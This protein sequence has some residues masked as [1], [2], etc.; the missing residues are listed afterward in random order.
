[1]LDFGFVDDIK[2]I[3]ETIREHAKSRTAHE[4]EV[5]GRL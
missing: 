1:M 3:K 4:N 2:E 5:I